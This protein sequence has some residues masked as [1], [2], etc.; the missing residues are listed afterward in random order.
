MG[1]RAGGPAALKDPP[2]AEVSDKRGEASKGV[3]RQALPDK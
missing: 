3:K 2:R 1:F